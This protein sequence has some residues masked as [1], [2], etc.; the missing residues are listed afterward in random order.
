ME[1]LGQSDVIYWTRVQEERFKDNPAEYE[2]IKDDFIMT[3]AVM[4][5]AKADAISLWLREPT[6]NNIEDQ[7][8]SKELM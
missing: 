2:A 5:H 7:R 3:P 6:L 8:I 4:T 1:V